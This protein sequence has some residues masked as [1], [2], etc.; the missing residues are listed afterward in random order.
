MV[1]GHNQP[2][3]APAEIALAVRD[4]HAFLDSATQRR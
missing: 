2:F 3:D 1:N 4:L